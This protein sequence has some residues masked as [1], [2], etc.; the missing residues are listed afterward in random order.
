MQE[1]PIRSQHNFLRLQLREKQYNNGVRDKGRAGKT[2][3]DFVKM[4]QSKSTKM[5]K[6]EAVALRS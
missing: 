3:D 1:V 6:P 4:P 5:D 2:I